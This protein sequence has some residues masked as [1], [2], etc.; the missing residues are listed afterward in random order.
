MKYKLWLDDIRPK[1]DDELGVKWLWY[2]TAE[3]MMVD[4][5]SYLNWQPQSNQIEL[6][7]LDNDLGENMTEG[8]KVLDWLE[9]WEITIPFAI[10][11]HTSNPVARERMR[12][13]IQRNGWTEVR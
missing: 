10:H 3:D 5:C 11:I 12:A 2:K 9:T 4:L 7:S 1:P 8:Y 6:I 13:I